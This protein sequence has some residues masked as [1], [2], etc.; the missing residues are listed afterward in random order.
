MVEPDLPVVLGE[1][2]V[3]L[4]EAKDLCTRCDRNRLR[5]LH[6]D[7]QNSIVV[8]QLSFNNCLYPSHQQSNSAIQNS[9]PIL[10]AR[11]RPGRHCPKARPPHTARRINGLG[12]RPEQPI[13][14]RP[15][16]GERGVPRTRAHQCA[17][18]VSQ[19]GILRKDD[20]LEVVFNPGTDK[21]EKQFLGP[22]PAFCGSTGVG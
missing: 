12:W 9:L 16:S 15:R 7:N 18:Y 17:F 20:F 6:D 11:Q 19:F 3:I 21:V 4:S 8:Q 1:A 5:Q 13:Q 2:V 22:A 10:R 14:S